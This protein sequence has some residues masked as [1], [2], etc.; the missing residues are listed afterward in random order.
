LHISSASDELL[1]AA[2]IDGAALHFRRII[3]DHYAG[4]H[5]LWADFLMAV[6]NFIGPLVP[7]R[8]T[9]P[10]HRL[11]V[12]LCVIHWYSSATAIY[13]QHSPL[14]YLPGLQRRCRRHYGGSRRLGYRG[15]ICR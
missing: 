11:I 8:L 9:S 2:R 5:Q 10:A 12:P 4:S 1:D 6:N 14:P 15:G 13:H 7:S 3:C